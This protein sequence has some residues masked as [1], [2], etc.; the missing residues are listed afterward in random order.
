MLGLATL[1]TPKIPGSAGTSWGS[2]IRRP[3]PLRWGSSTGTALEPAQFWVL[4]LSPGWA[5]AFPSYS[6]SSTGCRRSWSQ[7]LSLPLASPPTQQPVVHWGFSDHPSSEGPIPGRRLP[8]LAP[9][10]PL[11]GHLHPLQPL[12]APRPLPT[13]NRASPVPPEALLHGA[14]DMGAL[15]G[16]PKWSR[17]R[18]ASTQPIH[19]REPQSPGGL[20]PMSSRAA[21]TTA[22]SGT[23]A[24]RSSGHE[25]SV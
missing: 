12:Q 17:Q 23:A 5:A 11:T 21:C 8:C 16:L 10:R 22:S 4:S 14:R 24:G 13:G 2:D 9:A 18:L 6:W 7:R 1:L 15:G 3:L 19:P 25:H 20:S